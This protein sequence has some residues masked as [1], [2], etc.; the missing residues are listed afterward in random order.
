MSKKSAKSASEISGNT[1]QK[2][3]KKPKEN[4]RYCFTL[5]NYTEDELNKII[6]SAKSASFKYII[7]REVGEQGTPHL[8]GYINMSPH[9][10]SCSSFIK[11]LDNERIH[12]EPCKGSESQN[13][14][15]CSKDGKFE[16]N[17]YEA[18]EPLEIIDEML[19]WMKELENILLEKAN[20][21]AVYWIWEPIGGVGKSSFAKYLCHKYK[22]TYIDE[23]KKADLI[24][25]IYNI[26]DI[27]SKSIIVIDI[28]RDNGNKISYKA[29][30]QIKNGMICNTKYET[31][32]KLF[33]SPHVIIFS[34]S[35]PEIEKLSLDR[36]KIGEI[37]D[38]K[39]VWQTLTPTPNSGVAV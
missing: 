3:P 5:N 1:K 7:G 25:I 34:N 13:V 2:S 36:W 28:P 6:N 33:N 11:W 8:Q 37:K 24:N 10:K 39:L 38:K 32:M 19:E 9:K 23:G 16:S 30:E 21:R 26:K 18:P 31:G 14:K 4:M 20:K 17:F 35:Y 12:I 15:Y 27:N 22:A 29:I